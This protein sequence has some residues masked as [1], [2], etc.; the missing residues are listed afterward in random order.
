MKGNRCAS[1]RHNILQKYKFKIHTLT[2][3]Y[4]GKITKQGITRL[5]LGQSVPNLNMFLSKML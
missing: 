3:K 5:K 4:L 2:I 1:D